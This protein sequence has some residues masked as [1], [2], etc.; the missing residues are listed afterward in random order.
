MA[1]VTEPTKTGIAVAAASTASQ[2]QQWRKALASVR[3]GQGRAKIACVGDSNTVGWGAATGTSGLTAARVKSYPA[4]L[5]SIL[6]GMGYATNLQSFWGDGNLTANSIGYN[7][8]DPRLVLPGDWVMQSSALTYSLGGQLFRC[9]SPITSSLAFTP[10]GSVDTFVIYSVNNAGNGTFT[11]N[12]DGGAT[13]AT[14]NN[15]TTA[16]VQATTVTSTLGAHTLNMQRSAGG[17]IFIMGV[18]AYDSTASKIDILNMGSAGWK[19]TE[20]AYSANAWSPAPALTALDPDLTII[21]L[22][23]NDWKDT[24]TDLSTF[25]TNLQTVITA[26][27]AGG[28]SCILN[29][30]FP[31]QTTRASVAQQAP[32][33]SAIRSLGALNSCPVVNLTDRFVDW[34]T[35]NTLGFAYNDLHPNSYGY[36]DMAQ[37]QIAALLS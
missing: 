20:W 37:A 35:A 33:V 1:T 11:V 6:T 32:F 36:A 16:A 18:L 2:L 29:V 9:P 14:V 7:T 21:N 30:P 10:T 15:N 22:G 13:A 3:S 24:P 27:L 12:V 17:T 25:T 31:S 8:Y 34:A 23:I 26:A 5:S 19:A 4:Y 28:G